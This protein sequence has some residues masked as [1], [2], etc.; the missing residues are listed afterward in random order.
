M[1]RDDFLEHFRLNDQVHADHTLH[2]AYYGSIR[3]EERWISQKL[4]GQGGFGDVWKQEY[5]PGY[6]AAAVD[7]R[8]RAVKIINKR[9]TE[10]VGVDFKKELLAL[11][12]FS[13]EE[14]RQ[15]QAF[16]DFLGWY[17]TADSVFFAMEFFRH[18]DLSVHIASIREEDEIRDITMGVLRGLNIM[19][20]EGFTHRDLKPQVRPFCPGFR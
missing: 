4:I 19:H 7:T 20:T 12:K 6:A 11:S 2:I 9:A 13:K 8:V 14:Y 3:V 10:R 15:A 16:V 5:T 1:P 17:E 18:G